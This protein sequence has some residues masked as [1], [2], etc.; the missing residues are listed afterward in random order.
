MLTHVNGCF[1]V[2]STR[3]SLQSRYQWHPPQASWSVVVVA[4]LLATVVASLVLVY[5]MYRVT[6]SDIVLWG[7]VTLALYVV[8]ARHV[9]RE[10]A[11]A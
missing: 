6:G 3:A 5:A 9:T 1:H 4:Y 10:H 7:G 11:T 2:L 8:F